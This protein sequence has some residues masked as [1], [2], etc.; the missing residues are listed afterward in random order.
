MLASSSACSREPVTPSSRSP[1]RPIALA[2]ETCRPGRC[3]VGV[4]VTEVVEVDHAQVLTV[5]DELELVVSVVH[6][7]ST[8]AI[9]H[10]L[11][12]PTEAG[13]PSATDTPSKVEARVF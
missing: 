11:S 13:P 9:G 7:R 8:P 10:D 2:R 1:P 3:S 6:R 4:E 12:V 5:L